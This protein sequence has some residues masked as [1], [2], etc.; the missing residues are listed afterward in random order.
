[1]YLMLLFGAI[2]PLASAG[3]GMFVVMG[4]LFLGAIIVAAIISQKKAKAKDDAL[5]SVLFSLEDFRETDFV[6]GGEIM[7]FFYFAVDDRRD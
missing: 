7:D 5:K 1:M 4:L 6:K 3:I 2:L